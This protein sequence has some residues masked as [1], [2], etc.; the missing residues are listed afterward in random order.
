MK[1]QLLHF[2]PL[3][4]LALWFV[5]ASAQSAPPR[6]KLIDVWAYGD[7]VTDSTELDTEQNNLRFYCAP[8]GDIPLD[9]VE[10]QF[11]LEGYDKNWYT[12]FRD[13][14]FFYTDLPPGDYV[15]HA[16]CRF[17]GGEWGP[18][19]SHPV[20]IECPWWQTIW[21]RILFALLT[22]A[23]VSTLLYLYNER[24]R[25]NHKLRLERE[26]SIFRNDFVL[27]AGRDFRTPLT[28]IRSVVEKLTGAPNEHLTRTDIQHLRN[29]SNLLMRMVEDLMEY[30]TLGKEIDPANINDVV[31]LADIP[32]NN[33]CVLVVEHNEELAD[34][35]R[36]DLIKYVKPQV[37]Q[38]GA[39]VTEAIKA[40]APHLIII[41]SELPDVNAYDL[42]HEIRQQ[43]KM[44]ILLISN[45]N[46]KRSIIRALRS[47]ADDYLPKPFNVEVLTAI[48]LK[49][50]K[51]WNQYL[52]DKDAD[53]PPAKSSQP[54][55][56]NA[57]TDVLL[58][59]L[60]DR[61]FLEN[62]NLQINQGMAHEDFDVNKLAE[63]MKMSR[64][65]LGRK[66]K[67]L[68]DATAQE[69]LRSKRM[70]RAAA[71]L[72]DS[73]MNV[74]EI[75]YKVGISDSNTF[76]RR[77]KEHFGTSPSQYRSSKE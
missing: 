21:A 35:I 56:A 74:Q 72:R 4:L 67:Q 50:I 1:R 8:V 16:R 57:A 27:Q 32:L 28:V 70:E 23:V 38:K 7:I 43:S 2:L 17:P 60:S 6:I 25:L 10:Y 9:S 58:D 22:L 29:S 55:I 13:G 34:V 66:I 24:Q 52:H 26:I 15:F 69:Y 45:L 14:W 63:N 18:E 37:L 54:A 47:E 20:V 36:R 76:Y 12:P 33:H 73:D 65:Q 53:T 77:F 61:R 5:P 39:D 64:G 42:L 59:K 51:I 30:R 46:D 62:L 48:V 11:L 68:C 75:M 71:L 49:R 40:Y 3:L 31:E 19:I 44:P 41:D